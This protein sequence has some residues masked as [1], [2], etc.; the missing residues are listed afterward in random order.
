MVSASRSIDSHPQAGG[1]IW[2]LRQVGKDWIS[3]DYR[4]RPNL[5]R[6]WAMVVLME[7]DGHQTG[8]GS[9]AKAPRPA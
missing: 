1:I 8:Y 7:R 2:Q 6:N 5:T 3:G 9:D 4:A